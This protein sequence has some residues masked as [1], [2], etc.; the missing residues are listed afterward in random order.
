M[1]SQWKYIFIDLSKGYQFAHNST[2]VSIFSAPNYNSIF[3]NKG[4]ILKVEPNS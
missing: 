2:V 4:A 1:N 3:G